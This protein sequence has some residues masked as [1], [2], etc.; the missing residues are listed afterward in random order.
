SRLAARRPA[1]TRASRPAGS[2]A[3]TD[4]GREEFATASAISQVRV[5][6]APIA[7]PLRRTQPATILIRSRHGV[8]VHA[9]VAHPAGRGGRGGARPRPRRA[10]A[11]LLAAGAG[12]AARERAL[13]RGRGRRRGAGLLR[14]A[15]RAR[16]P[17]DGRPG[18]RPL[19]RAPEDDAAPL[20]GRSG[21][22]AFR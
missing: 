17:R 10:G 13:R 14:L 20:R 6:T 4:R 22:E 1:R 18:A 3:R 19:P 5:E 21:T 8:S 16:A 11:L 2:R 15:D 7:P 9:L 12:V